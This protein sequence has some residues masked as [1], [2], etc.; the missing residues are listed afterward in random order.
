[1][2]VCVCV[3][4]CE[5]VCVCVCVWER[6]FFF[7]ALLISPEQLGLN[8]TVLCNELKVPWLLHSSHKHDSQMNPGEMCIL[9]LDVNKLP[10]LL[11]VQMFVEDNIYNN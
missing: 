10:N 9:L 6:V 1:M 2:C 3:C 11:K 7:V 4:V 8:A 5:C